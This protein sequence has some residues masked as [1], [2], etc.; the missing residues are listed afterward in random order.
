MRSTP[1]SPTV[2]AELEDA[3]LRIPNPADPDVPVGGE[4]ANVV[5]RTWGEPLPHGERKPHWELAESLGII[6]NV[7]RRE[8]H[9]L[10]VARLPRRRVDAPARPDRLVPRRP[11]PRAW[12]DR[13]LAPGRRQR[14]LGPRHRPDPRQGGP[15]VRRRARR[16]LPGPD[17]RGAG[18]EPPPR[19]DPRRRDAADPLRR[20][21]GLVSPRG[22]RRRARY[23]RDPSRA[24]VRQGRDGQLRAAGALRRR[25]RVAH[26]VRRGA[27]PAA[28]PG[29][30]GRPHEHPRDGLRPGTQVRPRGLGA[31]R[32]ALARGQQHQQ[33]PRLPGA[34]DGHSVSV[35]GRREAGARPHPEWL[36]GWPCRGRSPR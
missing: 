33:L 32:R 8:D 14:R 26:G 17:R 18:H 21:L 30:P 25:A 36:G 13:G 4:E 11:L 7:A 27:P 1:T 6:D 16:P 12:D 19:R 10:R 15:D 5:V 29:L 35:R 34:A 2:E 24:P 23:A 28:G 3:L 22:W 9:R 31:G 20:V